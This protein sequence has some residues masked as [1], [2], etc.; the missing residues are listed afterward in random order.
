MNKKRRNHIIAV[1]VLALLTALMGACGSAPST[2]SAPAQSSQVSQP[3]PQQPA[4][5]TKKIHIKIATVG[6]PGDGI[7]GGLNYFA[8]EISNQTDGAITA[9]VFVSSQLGTY[10]DYIDGLKMGSIQMAEIDSSVLSTIAPKFSIFGI[11]YVASSTEE[12]RKALAGKAAE[13]LNEDLKK[14]GDLVVLGCIVSRYIPMM[15]FTWTEELARLTFVW[16]CFIGVAMALYKKGHMGIN[17]FY[18]KMS[19]KA[20]KFLDYFSVILVLVFSLIVTYNGIM[21]VIIAGG[22]VSPIINLS[23]R[24]FYAAVPVSFAIVSLLSALSLAQLI[25][26]SR[27][28]KYCNKRLH[29]AL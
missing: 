20:Q 15:T 29:K 6:N 16:F 13:I 17:Y 2:S 10:T 12:L 14:T 24:W 23:L 18:L 25:L 28:E 5:D 9:E 3:A 11:P 26:S 4:K 1:I 27:N 22:Q 21:L 19:K 7:T 8:K